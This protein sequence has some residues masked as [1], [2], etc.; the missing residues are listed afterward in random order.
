MRRHTR[1][2][3]FVSCEPRL[4]LRYQ[5]SP[6]YRP[7]PRRRLPAS[8]LRRCCATCTPPTAWL[9]PR[10]TPP[11]QRPRERCR[12]GPMIVANNI[13]LLCGMSFVGLASG[14]ETT[15]FGRYAVASPR[16]DTIIQVWVLAQSRVASINSITYV[17]L[18]LLLLYR[19]RY[20]VAL[21]RGFPHGVDCRRCNRDWIADGACRWTA[22]AVAS[23]R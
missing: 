8:H 15:P 19:Y 10:C 23:R 5:I 11:W 4:P 1:P 7:Q 3:A 2:H 22:C 21:S 17:L 18:V 20:Q 6:R 16:E 9:C 12:A 13:T 14:V